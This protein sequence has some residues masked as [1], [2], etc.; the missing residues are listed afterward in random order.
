VVAEVHVGLTD[1]FGDLSQRRR[2]HLIIVMDRPVNAPS[3]SSGNRRLR[4][5]THS[6]SGE[7]AQ[8]VEQAERVRP[9]FRLADT[10]KDR[11]RRVRNY[12]AACPLLEWG[13]ATAD[14]TPE[15]R[16]PLSGHS[17]VLRRSLACTYSRDLPFALGARL[18]VQ[19]SLNFCHQRGEVM[20]H[21][22]PENVMIDRFVA[23]DESIASADYLAPRNTWVPSPRGI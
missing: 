8:P 21:Y 10:A 9:S 6:I 11:S 1:T 15:G 22:R 20:R 3:T 7:R 2:R 13:P 4:W 17:S 5:R 14:V 19:Q 16:R 23:V 18:S 12:V